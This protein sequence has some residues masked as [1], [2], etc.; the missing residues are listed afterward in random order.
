MNDG[1][2]SFR[3]AIGQSDNLTVLSP[4]TLFGFE[5]LFTDTKSAENL[6]K[7][8][9]RREFSRDAGKRAVG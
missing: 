5:M 1:C 8:I 2:G 3:P 7:Q 6:T 4:R 9:V